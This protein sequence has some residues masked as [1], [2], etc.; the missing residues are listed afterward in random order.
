MDFD[1]KCK[2]RIIKRK[3]RNKEEN[4]NNE[5]TKIFNS[6]LNISKY[7]PIKIHDNIHKKL[8]I[9]NE[10]VKGNETNISTCIFQEKEIMKTSV[11]LFLLRIKQGLFHLII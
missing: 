9:K 11:K 8:L 6:S 1:Y 10:R 5:K 2:S 3:K 7:Q 4:K